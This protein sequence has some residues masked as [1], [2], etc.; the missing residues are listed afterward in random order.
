MHLRSKHRYDAQ[1]KTFISIASEF[2][3]TQPSSAD[4]D[5]A[6]SWLRTLVADCLA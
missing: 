5:D 2:A 4:A 1:E 6:E 3:A